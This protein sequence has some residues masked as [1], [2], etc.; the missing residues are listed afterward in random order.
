MSPRPTNGSESLWKEIVRVAGPYLLTL[1]AHSVRIACPLIVGVFLTLAPPLEEPMQWVF[2]VVA[3]VGC[4]FSVVVEVV[5]RAYEGL[6]LKAEQSQAAAQLVAVRDGIQP[7]AEMLADV[8]A[9]PKASRQESVTST[10]MQACSGLALIMKSVAGVRAVFYQVSDDQQ[11]L[12]AEA[13]CGRTENTPDP[14]DRGTPR[15]DAAFAMLQAGVSVF[16]ADVDDSAEVSATLGAYYGTRNSYQTFIS[17]PIIGGQTAH[18]MLTLDAPRVGD[19]LESDKH[20]VAIFANML[21]VSF[22]SVR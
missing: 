9:K 11:R 12:T 19:L 10:A 16:I 1:P 6:R 21:A 4:M 8:Q 2:L 20:L 5:A 14:F 18:G 22:A 3:L 17:A 7:V 13:Q 15:G